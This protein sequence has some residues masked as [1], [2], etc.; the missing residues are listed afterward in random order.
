MS[1]AKQGFLSP[2]IARWIA[3]HREANRSWFELA[4]DLNVC[5]QTQITNLANL[6]YEQSHLVICPLFLRGV[7]NFQAAILLAERGMTQEARSIVRGCFEAAFLLGALCH[8]KE[9]VIAAIF[10]EDQR[11]LKSLANAHLE[12]PL[13]GLTREHQRRL[14]E[15]VSFAAALPKQPRLSIDQVARIAGMHAEYVGAVTNHQ[16]RHVRGPPIAS[17]INSCATRAGKV[18]GAY[19]PDT[20]NG[21]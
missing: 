14:R 21:L 17:R 15:F 3:K 20:S 13:D 1:F 16:Y 18:S 10:A 7:S 11:Q 8:K 6:R 2:D 12:G 9:E 5:V 4:G 19:R